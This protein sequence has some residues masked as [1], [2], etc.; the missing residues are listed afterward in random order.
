MLT[1]I[2]VQSEDEK[3]MVSMTIYCTNIVITIVPHI[4]FKTHKN[5]INFRAS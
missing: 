3:E 4:L 2:S 1:L 5:D